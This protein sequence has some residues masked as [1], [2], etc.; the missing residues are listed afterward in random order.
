MGHV[1]DFHTHFLPAGAIRAEQTG[2]TWHGMKVEKAQESAKAAASRPV[3]GQ[4]SRKQAFQTRGG[5][6]PIGR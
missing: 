5:V 3:I 2:E 1:V 6:L 4:G